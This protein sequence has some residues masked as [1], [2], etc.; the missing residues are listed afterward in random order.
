[1]Q[2]DPI[3]QARLAPDSGQ[4][5]SARAA[6][7]LPEEPDNLDNLDEVALLLGQMQRDA[8]V[9]A[10]GSSP[11][12]NAFFAFVLG[13]GLAYVAIYVVQ[14]LMGTVI[15]ITHGNDY[16]NVPRVLGALGIGLVTALVTGIRLKLVARRT[17]QAL[18][19]YERELVRR[20]AAPLPER[21]QALPPQ[22]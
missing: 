9:E 21:G 22:P 3:G 13:A 4:E 10:E 1:V 15:G 8:A 5:A 19:D 14:S 12:L 2:T 17:R 11:G 6:A 18:H 20:G 16:L 7:Y